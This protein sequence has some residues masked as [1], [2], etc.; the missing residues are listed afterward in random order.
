MRVFTQKDGENAFTLRECT[1]EPTAL[2]FVDAKYSVF[3]RTRRR[4][5]YLL[6]L[7]M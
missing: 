2:L 1:F 6:R 4:G 5:V 7:L 3:D